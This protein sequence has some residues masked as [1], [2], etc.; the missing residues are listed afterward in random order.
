[1]MSLRETGSNRSLVAWFALAV[2]AFG[3][4]F[5]FV[6]SP[7]PASLLF[8]SMFIAFPAVG[9]VLEVR[10][11]EN[12]ISSILLAVGALAGLGGIGAGITVLAPAD[13]FLAGAV[14]WLQ[15]WLFFPIIGL[16][17]VLLLVFPTGRLLSHRWRWSLWAPAVFVVVASAGAAFYPW[18]PDDGGPNPLA[19][20]AMSGTWLFLQDA[21]GI[22]ILVAAL[23]G[24]A[25]VG[26]RYR[27]AG[28]VQRH[29]IKWFLAATAL[30]PIAVGIGDEYREVQGIV[31]PTALLLFPIAIGVAITRYRLYEI[32]R[33][34]SRTV[35]YGAMT[36]VLVSTYAGAVF[37]LRRVLP[38]QG[39]LTVAAS[40]LAAAALF[41]PLRRRT[42]AAVDRRFNRNRYDAG[43]VVDSF[44]TRLRSAEGTGGV[45]DN[46]LDATSA[47][48]QPSSISLW[49]RDG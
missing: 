2:A 27:R 17:L 49:L 31:V 40:T 9:L 44:G 16:V 14:R 26:V 41:D 24:I 29:Q 37:L 1:M 7:T 42:Q 36:A 25:S 12:P 22:P 5:T 13:S 28:E 19:V 4:F 6:E 23:A 8:G 46:L 30:L 38:G 18:A 32:D 10:V 15:T 34:I 35:T 33:I 11:P 3:A 43:R 47:T 45:V 21:A 48:V 20:E 39:Q